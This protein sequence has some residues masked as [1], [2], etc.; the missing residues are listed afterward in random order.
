MCQDNPTC[1]AIIP[2]RGGSKGIKLK[3]LKVINKKSLVRRAIETCQSAEI[4]SDILVSTDNRKIANEAIKHG[5]TVPFLRPDYLSGDLIGDFEVLEHCLQA[6]EKLKGITLDY[7]AMIQPT[8]PLREAQDLVA[9][10]EKI[11]NEK[12]DSVW[13]VSRSDKKHHPLKLIKVDENGRASLYDLAGKDII[14]RQQLQNYYY[15][16]GCYYFFSRKQILSKRSIYSD[17]FG[18]I[19]QDKTQISIDDIEDLKIARSIIKK[20]ENYA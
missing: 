13:S 8:S 1:L 15:R 10:F 18:I 19:I 9:G 5:A 17:N 20:K 2:A 6:Y 14:A 3:N 12:L 16:N 11:I 7:I 4:F